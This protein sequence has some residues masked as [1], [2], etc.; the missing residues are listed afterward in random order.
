MGYESSEIQ[1][2]TAAPYSPADHS[3]VGLHSGEI[4]WQER[5]KEND[6]DRHKG[7]RLVETK[8]ED[9]LELSQS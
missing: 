5:E 6:G 3:R 8:A 2:E 9:K 7:E 4:S 1:A